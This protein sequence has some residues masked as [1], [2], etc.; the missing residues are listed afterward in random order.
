MKGR[1]LASTMLSAASLLGA[2]AAFGQTAFTGPGSPPATTQNLPG[3]PGPRHPPR[4]DLASSSAYRVSLLATSAAFTGRSGATTTNAAFTATTGTGSTSPFNNASAVNADLF[5]ENRIR[6]NLRSRRQRLCGRLSSTRPADRSPL[7]APSPISRRT[8]TAR[9]ASATRA[10]RS[11]T[12]CTAS[13]RC[14]AAI[15]TTSPTAA[16]SRP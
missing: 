1:L 11:T 7:G 3:G 4:R 9:S 15:P 13:L 14:T 16:S 12:C 8:G 10:P 6:F 2:G 5:L